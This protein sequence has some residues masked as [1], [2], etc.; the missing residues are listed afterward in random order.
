MVK[1]LITITVVAVLV[2][3]VLWIGVRIPVRHRP[4]TPEKIRSLLATLLSNGTDGSVLFIHVRGDER[5]VQFR[6]RVDA[7]DRG[8]LEAAFPDAPWSHV[9]Y[10]GVATMLAQNS[11]PAARVPGE[12]AV[13]EFLSMQFDSDIATAQRYATA[14]LSEVYG[15]VPER[16]CYGVLRGDFASR[17]ISRARR[18]AASGTKG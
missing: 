1:V 16:D 17:V 15:V 5:I 13:S 8:R 7:L 18:P 6:L 9:F 10:E 11:I 12:G 4:L 2:W 3:F 14:V